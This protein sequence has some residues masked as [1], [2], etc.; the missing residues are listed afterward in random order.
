[1]MLSMMIL[2]G[3]TIIFTGLDGI[4]FS[5]PFNIDS[6]QIQSWGSF[7]STLFSQQLAAPRAYV[8]VVKPGE[9]KNPDTQCAPLFKHGLSE[10]FEMAQEGNQT[11]LLFS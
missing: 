7:N 11:T 8:E 4:E 5:Y 2:H 6:I 9:F 1:M 10:V 3:A